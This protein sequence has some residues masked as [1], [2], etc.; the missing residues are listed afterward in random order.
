MTRE[1]STYLNLLRL[2]AAMAVFLG[3]CAWL[4]TPGHFGVFMTHGWIMPVLVFFVLSGFVIGHAVEHRERGAA[5][6]AVNRAARIYSVALP[7]L[8][9]T[10]ALDAAGRHFAPTLYSAAWGYTIQHP[11]RQFLRSLL[12]VNEIWWS[13]SMPGSNGPFWSLA[14]EVWYYLAFGMLAFGRGWLRFLAVGLVLALAGPWVAMLFPIWLLGLGTCRLAGRGLVGRRTGWLLAAGGLILVAGLEAWATR[15]G[16]RSPPAPIF[17][18][19]REIGLDYA[20]ALGVAVHLLGMHAVA[21]RLGR[22]LGPATRPIG[23]MAGATFTLYLFHFPLAQCLAA[24]DP[25]APGSWA[26][27][28]LIVGGTLI[29]VLAVAEL[30][31]RRKDPW[32]RLFAGLL[33][34][35]AA[36]VLRLRPPRPA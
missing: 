23:W 1:F 31:E 12:F 17:V 8:V 36:S 4:W 7:A 15:A 5:D 2:G 25:W 6:Y 29:G 19:R 11:A 21:P 33:R 34:L 35:A 10:F 14:Y 3:H 28:C 13:R 26:S 24:L 16:L 20:I 9:G 32:R 27:L 18:H 22:L 30:T